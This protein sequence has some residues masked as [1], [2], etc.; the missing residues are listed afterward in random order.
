MI[1]SSLKVRSVFFAM[2][3]A[4]ATSQAF[5]VSTSPVVAPSVQQASASAEPIWPFPPAAAAAEPIWPFPPATNVAAAEPI[6]PFPPAA[7]VAS[8]EPIWPFP[9]AVS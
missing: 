3:L 7:N 9:P 8:A 4:F 2:I 5:A 6:W 1:G